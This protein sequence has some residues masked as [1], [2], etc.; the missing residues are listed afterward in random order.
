M[1]EKLEKVISVAFKK[2]NYDLKHAS[3]RVSNRP[4]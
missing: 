3:I 1:I 4:E 2:N